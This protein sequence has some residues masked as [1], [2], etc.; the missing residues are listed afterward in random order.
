MD[1]RPG[2]RCG[3]LAAFYVYAGVIGLWVFLA[4]A[5]WV[6]MAYAPWEFLAK[7]YGVSLLKGLLW[8]RHG[9]SGRFEVFFPLQIVARAGRNFYLGII[10]L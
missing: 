8:R 3:Q 5:L 7:Q 2:G 9:D 6:F 1:Q 4:H 10:K